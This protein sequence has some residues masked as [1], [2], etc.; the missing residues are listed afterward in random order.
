[1]LEMLQFILS[2]F[3]IF[4]GT[5]ILIGAVGNAIAK[6]ILACKGKTTCGF[7]DDDDD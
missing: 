5:V 1:M 2:D 6:I 3:W 4:A 7:F